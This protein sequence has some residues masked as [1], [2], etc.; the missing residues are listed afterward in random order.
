MKKPAEPVWID[1]A[2]GGLIVHLG[3]RIALLQAR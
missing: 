2:L 3:A 1:R